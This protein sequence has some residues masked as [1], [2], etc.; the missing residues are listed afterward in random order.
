MSL[1][2][3]IDNVGRVREA[4]QLCHV[5][6]EDPVVTIETS[7]VRHGVMNWHSQYPWLK[8]TCGIDTFLGDIEICERGAVVDCMACITRKPTT[9]TT[10]AT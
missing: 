4:L 2:D 10:G 5:L 6:N 3:D 9:W 8:T 1:I 7:A